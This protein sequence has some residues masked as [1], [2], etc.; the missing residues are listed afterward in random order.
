MK[1]IATTALAALL[2]CPAY[3]APN[4]AP[5][6]NVIERLEG[7]YGESRQ[8]IGVARQGAVM[9]IFANTETGSW[10]IVVTLPTGMAC[11]VATGQ[12]YENLS[13]TV[14]EGDPA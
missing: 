7:R 4:C 12:S 6:D 1:L 13:E 5:R 2:A 10:T 3:A 14:V 9:E 11:L 8:G